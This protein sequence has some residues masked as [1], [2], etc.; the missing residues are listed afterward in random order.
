MRARPPSFPFSHRTAACPPRER[1]ASALLRHAGVERVTRR[2]GFSP[3]TRNRRVARRHCLCRECVQRSFNL[4]MTQGVLQSAY[5]AVVNT[6]LTRV[7]LQGAR[8]RSLSSL[9]ASALP[10]TIPRITAP[11]IRHVESS[12]LPLLPYQSLSAG[13]FLFV[14]CTLVLN[15]SMAPSRLIAVIIYQGN[16][17]ESFSN[18]LNSAGSLFNS[19]GSAAM[20][21][22]LL[23][24]V[25]AADR[26][27]SVGR[28]AP[29]VRAGSDHTQCAGAFSRCTALRAER[30][31]LSS[32]HPLHA[33]A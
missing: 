19:S 1:S 13:A 11:H 10:N 12:R 32:S 6:F 21:F 18:L 4:N 5:Y 16:L 22:A 26:S 2:R 28:P 3:A 7:V 30:V 23:D 20:V 15:G 9:R 17:A 31:G 25:P 14:G 29:T 33:P 8:A 24:R 27:G